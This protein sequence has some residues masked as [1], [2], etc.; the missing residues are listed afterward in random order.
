MT[1]LI[2]QLQVTTLL[3]SE[4]NNLDTP[5]VRTST[6]GLRSLKYTGAILWNNIPQLIR[7]KARKPFTKELKKYF[8]DS[9][10]TD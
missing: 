10:I 9:Y 1:S 4:L 2:I 5:Q 3:V 7:S 8:I 6:Y